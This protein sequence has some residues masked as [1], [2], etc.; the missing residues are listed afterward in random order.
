[1]DL[2][3][4]QQ[5][6]Q[7]AGKWAVL[8]GLGIF[9]AKYFQY[10][11]VF[12]LILF[13]VKNLKKYWFMVFGAGVSAVLARLGITTLIRHFWQRPRP[14]I[15]NNV[16]LIINYSNEAS[17]PSGHAAFFFAIATVVYF[18]N[19]K[20]GILFFAGALLI[21]LGRIFVGIHWP[22]DI[23]AGA[24]VG[25]FSGWLIHKIFKKFLLKI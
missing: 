10:F 3:L 21:S 6:N 19:K 1:M 23:V 20:A 11:L 22:S 16:N 2:F 7:L 9:F 17:F 25:V 14:F 24:I 13:L 5:I 18:H 8:D 15:N 12:F 4:F